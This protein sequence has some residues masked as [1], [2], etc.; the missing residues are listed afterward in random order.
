MPAFAQPER[1]WRTRVGAVVGLILLVVAAA[2]IVALGIHQLAHA[3]NQIM[4]G[5][6]SE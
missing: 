5:Y 4:Q 2:L 6:L 1:Q 3:L